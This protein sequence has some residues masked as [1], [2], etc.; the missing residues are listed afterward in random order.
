MR[1][2][3]L[4]FDHVAIVDPECCSTPE[5]VYVAVSRARAFPARLSPRRITRCG[6]SPRPT[7][8]RDAATWDRAGVPGW[9]AGREGRAGMALSSPH[10]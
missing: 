2:K 8:R 9:A 5:E 1:L 3:G 10:V 4:E 7:G 6:G